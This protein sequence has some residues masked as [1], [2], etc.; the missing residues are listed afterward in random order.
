[1]SLRFASFTLSFVLWHSMSAGAGQAGARGLTTGEAIYH[2][3]L[4]RRDGRGGDD[5]ARAFHQINTPVIACIAMPR[6]T[7]K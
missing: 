4:L 2:N 5:D 3:D 6:L 7:R 1:M